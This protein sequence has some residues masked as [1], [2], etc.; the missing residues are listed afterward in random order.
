MVGLTSE[1]HKTLDM[2]ASI[3]APV[4]LIIAGNHD[5]T[6][7]ETWVKN[8]KSF[9]KGRKW[10]EVYDEARG[11]WFGKEGRAMKEGVRML[12]EGIHEVEVGNGGLLTVS[13]LVFS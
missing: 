12:E 3:D 4:K 13:V 2:L 9:L 7:D 5:R 10:E 6:L 1:Y 8:H 11:M